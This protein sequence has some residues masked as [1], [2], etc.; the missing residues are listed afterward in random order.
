MAYPNPRDLLISG[1]LR[2]LLLA[3]N[4]KGKAKLTFWLRELQGS[5][6][7]DVAHGLRMELDL[8]EHLQA[9]LFANK[10]LEPRTVELFLRLLKPGDTCIDVGAHIGFHSLVASRQVSRTGKV[11]ALDPQPYNCD[12]ILRNAQLNGFANL[13]VLIAAAGPADK[14]IELRQQPPSDRARLTLVGKGIN[15]SAQ[16]FFVPMQK[17]D[18]VIR[19]HDLNGIRLMKI[20]VEGFELEVLHGAEA[21]A[22]AIENIV[23]EILPDGDP[24]AT[25][26]IIAWLRARG[27]RIYDVEGAKWDVGKPCVENNVWATR[28][29][30]PAVMSSH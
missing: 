1:L 6:V 19:Y 17:L 5:V 28:L 26:G 15:D 21:S 29:S 12:R 14:M 30:S 25:R 3:P 9:D 2:R 20:D 13:S 22:D 8:S 4:F 18:T 24:D 10:T 16:A 23:L 11:L 7:C 27:F